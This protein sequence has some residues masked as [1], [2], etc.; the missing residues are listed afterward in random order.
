M[1]GVMPQI[2][3]TEEQARI[4]REAREPVVL[5]DAVGTVRIV[6]EPPDAVVL[7]EYHR[8]K[9]LG[10]E[11]EGIPSEKVSFYL[12]ALAAERIRL[13]HPLD[14]AYIDEFIGRLEKAEAA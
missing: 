14:D 1:E 9:M 3:L 2:I 10:V 6:S 13:G 12:K 7:A 4:I 11:E 8:D 5:T